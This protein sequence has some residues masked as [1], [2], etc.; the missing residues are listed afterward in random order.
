MIKDKVDVSRD[1]GLVHSV[2]AKVWTMPAHESAMVMMMMIYERKNSLNPTST[3]VAIV[4]RSTACGW[5][6]HSQVA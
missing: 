4:L 3:R 5:P 6:Q 1:R 2:I